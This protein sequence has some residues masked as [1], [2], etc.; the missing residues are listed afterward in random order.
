M[1]PPNRRW[2]SLI[3]ALAAL[4][5]P[6]AEENRPWPLVQADAI[7]QQSGRSGQVE[8]RLDASLGNPETF[9][10]EREGGKTTVVAGGPGGALYGVQES[11]APHSVVGAEGK[12][13]FELRGAVLLMLSPSWAYQ[14]DLSPQVYPWFF[15][16]PLMTRYLDYLLSARLNTLV[17]WSGHLFPHILDLPE[18]PDASQFSKEDIHRNQEQFRWLATECAKRN[19]SIL[20]H[21]YN[22][23]ISEHMARK[24]G[25]TGEDPSR[26]QV[27]DDFVRNYYRTILTRYF[28]EFPNVGLYI[29]PG[30][31]LDLD[32]QEAWFRD[33]V[34]KAARDSGKHPRLVIRDWTMDNG[35]RK[36]LPSLYDRLYSEL[37]HNDE[38]IT[39]PWP[40]L[41]HEEW[42]GVLNGHIVNLHD[43]EDTTPYRV[44]S[45]RLFNEMV[46]HWKDAGYFA[47]S[48]FYP[49]QGWCWPGTLDKLPEGKPLV[50]FERDE[51]WHLLE[52]RYL[53]RANRDISGEQAWAADWLG[54]KFAQP[55]AGLPLVEWYDLT[56]PI[57]PGL[58]NLT[59]VR[60]GNFFPTSV[61]W[62]QATVDDILSFRTRI[63]DERIKG[64]TGLT[65]QRYYSRP[66]D[67][68][69]ISLYRER[70]KTG[71]PSDLRSLPVAQ[72]AEYLAA[73]RDTGDFL[74]PDRLLEVYLDMARQAQQRAEAVATLKTNQPDEIARFASDARALVMTVEYYQIKVLAALNKRLLEKTGD[75]KYA[76]EMSRLMEASVPKYEEMIDFA[77]THYR[78]GSSMF[79]AES[80]DAT[81]EKKVK[82]DLETQRAWLAARQ[83]GSKN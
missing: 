41:R 57:L 3:F 75:E 42:K 52:G 79:S 25:R 4:N 13:D 31:S 9:R 29:C 61:G 33:V 68:Y 37:K 18:Y 64:P 30:E 78:A 11:V 44:G 62:V 54:R 45:P 22:I 51:L 47:G 46:G 58:Q 32:Q 17:L 40:D 20:T 60:F 36:N 8:Y 21:F 73:G 15:D 48:W 27:P 65:K 69:T 7:L 67:A 2:I 76:R 6:A 53:W 63:D 28:A 77:K 26:Y 70:F 49:P 35:F 74:R 10:L 82:V 50:A 16:K 19:I 66:I 34:F 55:A 83:A 1:N 38:S 56:G 5:S 23:H 24:L 71:Q 39:S 81:L 14:S 72:L 80:W 43:P 12:P 59:A